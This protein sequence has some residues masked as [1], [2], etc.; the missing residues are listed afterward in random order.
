MKKANQNIIIIHSNKKEYTKKVL[1]TY[2]HGRT[3]FNASPL[4]TFQTSSCRNFDAR[5]TRC[6]HPKLYTNVKIFIVFFYFSS[7]KQK[8]LSHHF[9]SLS[10]HPHDS[11]ILLLYFLRFYYSCPSFIKV[12]DRLQPQLPT[13]TKFHISDIFILNPLPLCCCTTLHNCYS[14]HQ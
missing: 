2:H 10:I 6:V 4:V 9:H 7:F 5:L 13:L 11:T 12:Y 14:T 3:Y 8:D 1:L